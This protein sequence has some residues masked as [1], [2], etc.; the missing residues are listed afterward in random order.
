MKNFDL[1]RRADACADRGSQFI[2]AGALDPIHAR[3]LALVS[4]RRR[5]A[6]F[7]LVRDFDRR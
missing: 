5:N 3:I 7:E 1:C 2:T 4:M 6:R